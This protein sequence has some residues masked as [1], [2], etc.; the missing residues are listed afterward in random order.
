M[1]NKEQLIIIRTIRD[2][3]NLELYLEDKEY[4]AFDTETTGVTKDDKI[5]GF[6][7]SAEVDKGYY[8]ILSEWNV[9]QQ[10][11]IDLETQKEAEEFLYRLVNKKLIMQNATFDCQMVL[12]NYDMDLMKYVHTDTMILAHLLDEN[13]SVG[14]KELGVSIFGEDARKEQQEM[15]ESVHKNGGVL[16]K[17]KYELYK[18]D[19][20]LI[21][22]YGAKDAILTLKLFYE[23]V[24]ELFDQNLDKF[25]YN[26]ESM[27]LLRGPTYHLNTTGLKID[28]EKLSKLKQEL[29]TECLEAK[30]FIMKEIFPHVK[31]KYPG[32]GK[33]NH[34]NIGATQQRAWLL[35][36][37][38]GE[39]F[40]TLTDGGKEVCKALGMERLPYTLRAKRDFIELITS[41]K[42][43]VYQ[44]AKLNPKT[45]KMSR[46]KRVG[47]PWQYMTCGK[48]SLGKLATKY[49]WVQRLLEYS[50][51]L[52]LLNTYVE[53]IEARM[54]Y[55]IIHPNFLQHGTT[56]GRYSCKNPNF[57]NLPR[58]DKRVKACI[59]ARPGKVFVGADH[60]QLE[61]R[62]F[63][64]LSGDETLCRSFLEGDDFYSVVG[65]PVFGV[66]DCTLKKDD[67]P[68]SFA[69]KYKKLRD[70]AKIIALATPYGTLAPQMSSE[71]EL[72][73]GLTKN[74]EECQ[75]IIDDYFKAY[76]KVHKL[77]LDAHEQAKIHGVVYSLF[78]RPRR[79][80]KAQAI[81]SLYGKNTKHELLPRE[82]RNLLNL[83]MNHPVQS[84]G[85]SIMNRNMIDFLKQIKLAEIQDCRIVLQV[86]D[87]LVAECREEDAQDVARILQA[88]MENSVILSGVDLQAKPLI[89]KSLDKV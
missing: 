75:E 52:K 15:K 38:L 88:S 41:N 46:P 8:I 77:M 16:T 57:Q 34:F 18:A 65:Q 79:I 11:L 85:A 78:G 21:A 50:K 1:E 54:R 49:K 32:T 36:Y 58:D 40:N 10:K 66:Y 42:G 43:R 37:I 62:V 29:Q 17:A 48:V 71:I 86:H 87:S 47:D 14:L 44:Q 19:S 25:F 30:A 61:P 68:N 51:S 45:G 4:I 80:P 24:P 74:M 72:K 28:P 89:G 81:P 55:G 2:M 84:T 35:Y 76:P 60:S 70:M 12:Q 59:I 27:P 20:E 73:A 63:A 31:D 7:V 67:S 64:S 26:D 6:S 53:G 22:R 3:L 33:T 69:V 82:A 83:A 5:I 9:E 13:R 56:S 39:S 23:L